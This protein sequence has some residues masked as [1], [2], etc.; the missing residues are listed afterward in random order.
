MCS[1]RPLRCRITKLRFEKTRR[2]RAGWSQ[3]SYSTQMHLVIFTRANPWTVVRRAKSPLKRPQFPTPAIYRVR[4]Y[5]QSQIQ[6]A[7]L[8]RPRN[9][10]LFQ[11][12][13]S[14]VVPL[15]YP[16]LSARHKKLFSR[17]NLRQMRSNRSQ[18][19]RRNPKY[20]CAA[21]MLTKHRME[22]FW[23]SSCLCWGHSVR[24]R[25]HH[26]KSSNKRNLSS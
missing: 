22:N 15:P 24:L 1:V 3:R 18:Q 8:T 11:T 7:C 5:M 6:S 4:L 26:I 20:R 13:W 2:R 14:K 16:Q 12:S 19:N 17:K 25:Y 9:V 21:S 23:R 10:Q